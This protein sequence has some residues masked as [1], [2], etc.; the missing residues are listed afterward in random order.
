MR[1]WGW[2]WWLEKR[3][4]KEACAFSYLLWHIE[5]DNSKLIQL[6]CV[7]HLDKQVEFILLEL[8]KTAPYIDG[9]MVV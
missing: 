5:T 2:R 4:L 3:P 6:T 9:Y 1:T 8:Y 7:I